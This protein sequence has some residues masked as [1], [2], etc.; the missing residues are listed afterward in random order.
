MEEASGDNARG[1]EEEEKEPRPS[2]FPLFPA[3]DSSNLD[4][5]NSSQW[6][7]NSSFTADISTIHASV[8]QN[9]AA[10]DVG[11]DL[12][13]EEAVP[14]K[15]PAYVLLESSSSDREDEKRRKKKK[16][17]SRREKY[18]ER[19]VESGVSRK[20]RVDIWARSGG[21]SAKDYYFDTKGDR[22]NLAFGCLY[23]MDVAR[24][25][26]CNQT[27][28]S[29]SYFQ[30]FSQWRKRDLAADSDGDGDSL[31]GKLREAGRYYSAKYVALERHKGFKHLRVTSVNE[32]AAIPEVFIPFG[33]TG[34]PE[35]SLNIEL[36]ESWEDEVLRKTKEFNKMSREFPH[37][38]KVW[39]AFAE[40]QDRV[41]ARQPQKAARLQ[42][43]EKKISILE[44]AVE[45]N[46]ENE[47]LLLNLLKACQGRDN[48]EV[49]MERWEKILVQNSGSC[50]LWKE[51]L[52][53]CQGDFSRFKVSQMRKLY[54]YGIQALSAACTKLLRQANQTYR[55]QKPDP[56]LVQQ[57]LGL[58][59]IFVS[60]CRFEWQSGYK[61]LA[62]GLFQA[63][64]EYNLFCPSLLLTEQSKQRLFEH[65]WNSDGARI[66]ED[67]ALGWSKWLEKEEESRQKIIAEESSQDNEE[68]GWTGWS[69]PLKKTVIEKGADT[70][71]EVDGEHEKAGEEE[72]EE[73]MKQEEDVETLL[74]KL[75][76]S[77][78]A[79]TDSEVKDPLMWTR[80]SEEE[81][82]RDAEQWMPVRQNSGGSAANDNP[83]IQGDEQL[84]RVILFED[85]SEYLFS[86]CSEEA[87]FFLLSQFIEFFGGRV[88]IGLC[89]NSPSWKENNLSWEIFPDSIL[90]EL[91]KVHEVICQKSK[92]SSNLTLESLLG[93]LNSVSSQTTIMKFLRNTIW[94]CLNVFPRNYILEEAL[95]AAEELFA[96]KMKS[97]TASVTPSRALAKSL[98]KS[99]RQD[100]LL[101]GVYARFEAAHGNLDLARKVFDMALTSVE[102]LPM[103][104]RT[105]VPIVPLLYF[106]YSEVEVAA[107]ESDSDRNPSPVRAVHILSCLGSGAKYSTF[108]S[109][110][111][112]LQVLR[113]RQ[114]FREQIK[115]TYT[116][117]THGDIKD[118]AI[119]LICSACLFEDLTTGWGAGLAIFEEAFSKVLPERRRGSSQMESLFNCYIEML[120]K[121]IKRSKFS[122]AWDRIVHGLQLYP[123]SPRM[124]GTFVRMGY[125]YIVPNKLRQILDEYCNRKPSL[126]VWLFALSLELEKSGSYHRIHALFERAL[127]DDKLQKSVILW[128]CYLAFEIHLGNLSA[129][130]RIFYRAVHACPWSKK[131]WLDGFLKL[132]TVLS[133]KE[134]SDLQEVMRD[135]EL[136]L[137]TDIYEILL[138]DDINV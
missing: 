106:W 84:S 128:R 47:D 132:H 116:A 136:H 32:F 103:D 79:E 119:A 95:L 60:L 138:Q 109:Q 53:V 12:A 44:K 76:I 24:Y 123:Y 112:S 59:D 127:A 63:E 3:A 10:V 30:V 13:E 27:N 75:G 15:Q 57:E 14:R 88:S 40:F 131:L 64:I 23:R 66:G 94:L 33:Q 111:S 130:R 51:F 126:I 93:R 113:A 38:E 68:G 121:N 120:Q 91:R 115:S 69:E 34:T 73:E 21:K 62:T 74:K 83:A 35:T 124:F 16:K 41:A 107:C 80:W 17:T 50:K 100:I 19:E 56:H 48:V 46:P 85:V 89:T 72:F 99:D 82:Q 135:K 45:L 137:R 67:G 49:L 129:A 125:P 61:E 86:L 22:D 105:N 78:D 118:Q 70:S 133:A 26:L 29:G 43:M 2:L 104:L 96:T 134:L 9:D 37:D 54:A 65:F 77:V 31:D 117:W 25:R 1:E 87:R 7:S 71:R 98:L 5:F 18:R 36:E 114:G 108:Q 39:L 110:P 11:S 97:C 42:T 122:K 81:T 102:G 92:S 8:V 101:C 58:V 55:E 20:S 6:L 90:E 52:Q 28:T 4:N